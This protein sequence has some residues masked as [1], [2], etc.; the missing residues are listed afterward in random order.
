MQTK[1]MKQKKDKKSRNQQTGP[2]KI[3]CP[4]I[5][6]PYQKTKGELQ[7]YNKTYPRQA[8]P[9]F[10]QMRNHTTTVT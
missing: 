1:K 2:K 9:T 8:H 6:Y 4:P 5:T 10:H 3:S 7:K